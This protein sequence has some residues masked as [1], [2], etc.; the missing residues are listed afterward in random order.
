MTAQAVRR[1]HEQVAVPSGGARLVWPDLGLEHPAYSREEVSQTSFVE[2][3][4]MPSL[5]HLSVIA[6]GSDR[7]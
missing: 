4:L 1:A 2:R 3:R 5:A 7:A 6:R